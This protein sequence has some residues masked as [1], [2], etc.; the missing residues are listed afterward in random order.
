MYMG[1]SGSKICNRFNIVLQ[2]KK[3]IVSVEQ[4]CS[5]MYNTS[6]DHF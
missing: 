2:Q 1:I 3:K 6:I 4:K 5:N